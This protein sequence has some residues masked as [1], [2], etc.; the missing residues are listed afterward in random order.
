M[1]KLTLEIDSLQV[2]TFATEDAGNGRGTVIGEGLGSTEY[3][4]CG[5][6]CTVG[7]DLTNCNTREFV[8]CFC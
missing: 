5:A 6:E 7:T 2:Q 4:R 1:K 3:T 8:D